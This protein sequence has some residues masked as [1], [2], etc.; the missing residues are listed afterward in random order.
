M[1]FL[2][3]IWW[4]ETG[5]GVWDVVSPADM[6]GGDWRASIGCCLLGLGLDYGCS[7]GRLGFAGT[8]AF[9]VY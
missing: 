9:L 3:R 1:L 5:E 2:Q 7:A 8:W 4:V 6:V